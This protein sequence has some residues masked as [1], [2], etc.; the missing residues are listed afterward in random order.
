M[1]TAPAGS[2]KGIASL[3]TS[4]IKGEYGAGLPGLYL[5][6]SGVNAGSWILRYQMDGRRRRIGLGSTEMVTLAQARGLAAET[7]VM[8][9]D[10]VDPLEAKKVEVPKKLPKQQ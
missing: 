9:A 5:N 6:V 1:A 3:L 10:G 4:G 8:I 7:R 2:V